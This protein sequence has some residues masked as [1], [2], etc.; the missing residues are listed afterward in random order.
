MAK[1]HASDKP[2][3]QSQKLDFESDRDLECPFPCFAGTTF[4]SNMRLI[5][6]LILGGVIVAGSMAGAA[7]VRERF[8]K[9]EFTDASG[10]KLRYRLLKPKDYDPNR[11]Y[12]LVVFLHGAGERGSDNTAQLVHAMADF[13]S[14]RIMEN[15]PAFV[16]APQCPDEK[17]WVEVPWTD[18]DHEMPKEPSQSLRQTLELVAALQEEFSIDPARRY[19]TGLS[20]GGFGVWDAIQRRPELFAAAAPVCGGADAR[21]A[22]RI[23]DVPVWA[24]HGDQDDAVKVRRSRDMIAAIKAAG[25]SP[26]YTE[27]K[28]VGHDSWTATYQDPEL[29]KWLFAQKRVAKP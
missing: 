4:S 28:G 6:G 12:P 3:F 22:K 15:Y 7:D 21:L 27:Y 19:I 5:F 16:I 9:R 25:G 24:F 23:K 1:S 11:K 2:P 14:D 13:A 20:M 26:K 8:E 18:E 17:K 29:Y 10:D